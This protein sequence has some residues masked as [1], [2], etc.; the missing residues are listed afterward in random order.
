MRNYLY[1]HIE[2]SENLEE[3][4]ITFTRKSAVDQR[5]FNII[6]K[7]YNPVMGQKLFFLPGVNIPRV[8]LRNFILDYNIQVVR[9]YDEAHVIFGNETSNSKVLNKHWENI[10]PLSI[11][12]DCVEALISLEKL[13]DYY[14]NNIKTVLEYYSE[15]IILASWDSFKTLANEDLYKSL[16]VNHGT[17][18]D[19]ARQSRSFSFIDE[20][21]IDL[22]AYTEPLEILHESSIISQLNGN[23]SIVINKEVFEQLEN[24]FDSS[25]TDN[26]IVAM[27]IMA[28]A[29][30]KESLYYLL[31]LMENNSRKITDC[32]IVN[33]VNFKSLLSYLKVDKHNLNF[34]IDDKIQKLMEKNV[35]TEEMLNR[36][37]AE[38]FN[39]DTT[40]FYSQKLRIKTITVTDEIAEYFN[41][42][43]NFIVK[44]D[45]IPKEKEEA[46]L[47]D[48]KESIPTWM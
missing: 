46:P 31:K 37:I 35:L 11:F 7:E 8:K 6:E 2:A 41:S 27:E 16:I 28:N 24:M 1:A 15:D 22:V 4:K 34:S 26:H 12:K 13:D 38:N 30:Y 33:H 45:F 40:T 19:D 39:G 25:D 44:E 42:N 29:K 21:Y 14:V 9:N 3:L 47:E 10:I 23:D 20:D 18:V 48:S 43:Y 32:H 17:R 36:L 5:A